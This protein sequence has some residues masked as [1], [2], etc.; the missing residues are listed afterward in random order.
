MSNENPTVQE[1]ADIVLA[2]NDKM[3]DT[4]YNKLD[5]NYE[6]FEGQP[7]CE[8]LTDGNVSHIKLLGL[9]VWDSEDGSIFVWG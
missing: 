2:L 3:S 9:Y 7:I 8:L 5:T 4:I 6:M 1:L